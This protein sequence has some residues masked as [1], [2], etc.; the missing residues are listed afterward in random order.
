MR[1]AVTSES[2]V[3]AGDKGRILSRKEIE[4]VNIAVKAARQI[5]INAKATD[6]L[7]MLNVVAARIPGQTKQSGFNA[8][9]VEFLDVQRN[10]VM[11][12]TEHLVNTGGDFDIDTLS[13]MV[14]SLG[15]DGFLPQYDEYLDDEGVFDREILLADFK[16]SSDRVLEEVRVFANK[17]NENI[18][19]MAEAAETKE[20]YEKSDKLRKKLYVGEKLK[21]LELKVLKGVKNSFI[22]ISTN[23][24]VDSMSDSLRNMDAAVEVNTPISFGIFDPIIKKLSDGKED[25][26]KYSDEDY[27][28]VLRS[29]QEAMQGK[30]G[31]GVYATAMKVNSLIQASYLFYV[32]HYKDKYAATIK[33]SGKRNGIYKDPFSFNVSISYYSTIQ[34]K[35]IKVQRSS[36]ADIDENLIVK[37]VSNN[38]TLKKALLQEN[39]FEL[40]KD[41]ILKPFM[42]IILDKLGDTYINNYHS[43]EAV[44]TAISTVES[45]LGYRIESELRKQM[46]AGKTAFKELITDYLLEGDT[47]ALILS[48]VVG[49]QNSAEI[50]SQFL[51]AATDNA[52]ELLLGKI[53]SNP[54]TVSMIT[55]MMTVGFDVETMIDFLFDPKMDGIIALMGDKIY[56]AEGSFITAKDIESM[57]IGKSAFGKSVIT[58]LNISDD[59][60]KLRS[61]RS[62]MENFKVDQHKLDGM[63]ENLFDAKKLYKAIVND[64][65]NM[66]AVQSNDKRKSHVINPDMLIFLH[67]QSRLIFKTMYELETFYTPTL[68]DS[69]EAIRTL[70]KGARNEVTYKKIY[71]YLGETS[72]TS[73]FE[74]AVPD[75][76]TTDGKKL[77]G[78][79]IDE[80]DVKMAHDLSTPPGRKAFV[81]NF[82]SYFEK[83]KVLIE[84]AGGG[85]AFLNKVGPVDIFG[86]SVPVYGVP[87]ISKRVIEEADESN[88]K[89]GVKSMLNRVEGKEVLNRLNR[90]M[91][92][93]FSLYAMI[94]T[95]GRKVKGGILHLF[96][97]IN[98]KLARYQKSHKEIYDIAVGKG[99][100]KA[101]Q[102]LHKELVQGKVKTE[103]E[104]EEARVRKMDV[105]ERNEYHREKTAELNEKAAR[106]VE[107]DMMSGRMSDEDRGGPP[108]KKDYSF[109]MRYGDE[110]II[111]T[112]SNAGKVFK[113]KFGS[114]NKD[115]ESPFGESYFLGGNYDSPVPEAYRLFKSES[116]GDLSNST[117]TSL[118]GL[119]GI[120]NREFLDVLAMHKYQIGLETT[121]TGS[122]TPKENGVKSRVLSYAGLGGKSL[123]VPMYNVYIDGEIKKVPSPL[124]T[125]EDPNIILDGQK[126]AYFSYENS[127]IRAKLDDVHQKLY[128]SLILESDIVL[129]A[130]RQTVTASTEANAIFDPWEIVKS[131]ALKMEATMVGN[132]HAADTASTIMQVSGQ[133]STEN[134]FRKFNRTKVIPKALLADKPRAIFIPSAFSSSKGAD[135]S[136]TDRAYLENAYDTKSIKDEQKKS[137]V[138]FINDLDVNI[139]GE[140]VDSI[141][142]YGISMNNL[143]L[144]DSKTELAGK[145][146]SL[147]IVRGITNSLN[148]K[149]Y[150]VTEVPGKITVSR[151]AGAEVF[152]IIDNKDKGAVKSIRLLKDVDSGDLYLPARPVLDNHIKIELASRG[153]I[154]VPIKK[155]G[156][157]KLPILKEINTEAAMMVST[158]TG[159]VVFSV[160]RDK[161]GVRNYMEVIPV[162]KG[163]SGDTKIRNGKHLV[164]LSVY[165]SLV[166][167]LENAEDSKISC[168]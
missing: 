156:N 3:I 146:G 129:V 58:L 160:S 140:G 141:S 162:S 57:E 64:D 150:K 110:T 38:E 107:E 48:R 39:E 143:L 81:A 15:K 18:L 87:D 90:E 49:R 2:S 111:S 54:A 105:Q 52:K 31:I 37:E 51:S 92:M 19:R 133:M 62:L 158:T 65:I 136:M 145:E 27:T 103:E 35:N 73:F 88:I 139:A 113:G 142:F 116:K 66:V 165:D 152:T 20:E 104:Y 161:L 61:I 149:L 118:M 102:N 4:E 14:N 5:F 23:I 1:D 159:D 109:K 41:E 29:E 46:G 67:P 112:S 154:S 125:R 16:K 82:P 95:D 119:P 114:S 7:K 13:I 132:Y 155:L 130:E 71:D 69:M 43:K 56:N 147:D 167:S 127:S 101:A 120:E 135:A 117:T 32:R 74:N 47:L 78:Y 76:N 157:V 99:M 131:S 59:L 9:V 168:I 11:A 30:E 40:N 148:S 79:S 166:K 63:I 21:K 100:S 106:S 164:S 151:V 36:F 26:R 97:G 72:V 77:V 70:G 83:T 60:R 98:M 134:S 53:R 68:V 94:V 24:I 126:M 89:G 22:N 44:E 6:F 137:V 86:V 93:N 115:A 25:S 144:M 128:E 163:V 124:I 108:E 55:A 122:G 28:Y 8:R 12:P 123:T 10:M 85:N 138:M 91:H 34:D 33:S 80:D 75:N 121:Y 96:D 50:Q 84:A 42:D 153:V 45:L 17:Y